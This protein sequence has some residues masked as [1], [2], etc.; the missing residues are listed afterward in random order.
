MWDLLLAY[1]EQL[2]E[3]QVID[4]ADL[5]LLAEQ[6]LAREPLT[7]YAAVVIDEAQDLSCAMVR[8][9]HRLVG[10]AENGLTLIGDGQQAIYPGGWTLAEAGVSV[11]GR[12]VVLDINYRNTEQIHD[13]AR[14]IV[15]GDEYADLEGSTRPGEVASMVPR[16]GVAPYWQE[17]HDRQQQAAQM[18]AAVREALFDP[19][20]DPG[21]V[22]VLC[23]TRAGVRWATTV[24]RQAGLPV[25]QLTSYQGSRSA[26]ILV[27]TVKRAKGLELKQVVLP[28]LP[29]EVTGP[30]PDGDAARERWELLRR[31][32]YVGMTRARDRLWAQV[33]A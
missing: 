21:D 19:G 29:R 11:A 3:Q 14:L 1:Q 6:E 16:Q 17:Y 26:G 20:T 25:T 7:G 18:L 27:G 9:L 4:F 23:L 30:A 31:E 24:L 22:G 5:V 10:D 2:R 13:F 8:L 28:D 15:E 32:A 12:G 33:E